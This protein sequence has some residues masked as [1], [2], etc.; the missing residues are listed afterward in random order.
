VTTIIV[1]ERAVAADGMVSGGGYVSW[2]NDVKITRYDS[3]IPGGICGILGA[4]SLE[5][6]KSAW[7]RGELADL[8]AKT[9]WTFLK[10]AYG[11]K[12]AC[13]YTSDYP[14][15]DPMPIPMAWGSGGLI[16]RALL[17]ADVPLNRI[18][19]IVTEMD[20]HSG[21]KWTVLERR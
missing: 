14:Y 3:P 10:V 16:A 12:V 4:C 6:M 2:S 11:D 19:E 18:I 5:H 20:H 13:E 9:D 21:G 8:K 17:K 1:T 15:S 7:M